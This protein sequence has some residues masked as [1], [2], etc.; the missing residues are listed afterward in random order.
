MKSVEII[1]RDVGRALRREMISRVAC[2]VPDSWIVS[3]K[4]N[5]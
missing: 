5:E 2:L 4:S 3:E 1:D